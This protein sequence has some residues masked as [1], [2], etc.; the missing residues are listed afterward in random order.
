MNQ[1]IS[2]AALALGSM[3]SLPSH[4]L[5]IVI[6]NDDGLTSNVKA[7]YD[8]LKAAG[9]DVIVSVPCTQ[10]SGRGGAVVMY[11][12]NTLTATQDADITRNGGCRNGAAKT[13]EP[14]VGPMTR[15]GFDNGDWFYVHGTPVMA[16]MYGLD[17]PATKR[18]GKAPDLVVSGPNEGANVGGLNITSGT[19][20]ITQFALIRNIPAIAFSVSSNAVDDVSLANP[21]SQTAASLSLK[22][23]QL[24][25]SQ[26]ESAGLLPKGVALN[27]NFPSS[28]SATSAFAFSRIGTFNL[29]ELGFQ[30][31]APYGYRLASRN[32]PATA[33]AAQ[34]EDESV[35]VSDRISVSAMQLA[36]DHRPAAQEW[37]RMRLDAAGS[38][39]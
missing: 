31:T 33:S 25:D 29:Y 32:N 35:V 11:S 39:K 37:L 23:I 4:A 27:V 30:S 16:L 8:T 22:L 6:S 5:N 36:F 10:Q 9:H 20:G 15:S 26:R 17:A 28:F 38:A 3:L 12:T 14:S 1:K 2:L 18:W 7:L 24:L 34:K 19:I 13:A 21:Q